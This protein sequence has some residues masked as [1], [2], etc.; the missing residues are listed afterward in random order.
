[1]PDPTSSL[2]AIALRPA[3]SAAIRHASRLFEERS[4]ADA[5]HNA[6]LLNHTISDTFNRI[7][8]GNVTDS[9]WRTLLATIDHKYIAPDFLKAPA[10]QDWLRQDVVEAHF[11]DLATD[12]IMGTSIDRTAEREHLAQAYSTFTGEHPRLANAPIDVV[13]GI[14]VAG[15]LASIP[16]SQRPLA[17]M[18]QQIHGSF[19]ER[20]D[21]L[22]ERHIASMTDLITERFPIV[23]QLLTP[24]AESVLS[25]ILSIR[26]LDP[27]GTRQRIRQLFKRAN[28]GD[29]S[30]IDEKVKH[31]IF[32]WA[33]RLCA[34]EKESLPL[35]KEIRALLV[36]SAPKWN[37]SIID[38]LICEAD[39][40]MDGALRR[41]RDAEGRD[42]RSVWFGLLIRAKGEEKALEWFDGENVLP[43]EGFFSGPGWVSWA[44]TSA[45]RGRWKE[46]AEVLKG[47][48]PMW[49]ETPA[50]AIVEGCVNAAFLLPEDFRSRVLDGVPLYHG[51]TPISRLDAIDHHSK[52]LECFG[53]ADRTLLG[54]VGKEWSML[55]A[56][57]SLWLQ[58]MDPDV[59]KR[60]AARERVSVEMGNGE[61]ALMLVPFCRSFEITYD[62]KPL[63]DYLRKRREL[64]GLDDRARVA[65][66]I[67]NAQ[68][69]NPQEFREYFDKNSDELTRVVPAEFFASRHVE[70][71]LEDESASTDARSAIERHRASLDEDHAKRLE[72][73]IDAHEGLDVRKKLEDLYQTTDNVIDLRNLIELL[74]QR[75]DREALRPLC[76]ELFRRLPTESG[77]IDVVIALSGPP[78]F[79]HEQI[80][81]FLKDNEH[82]VADSQR[83]LDLKS[84]ALIHAGLYVEAG[85][86]NRQSR[87]WRVTPENVRIGVN[88]AIA[89]GNWEA[90][91]GMV[92]EAWDLREEYDARELVALAHLAGQ[93]SQTLEQ[94][95]QLLKLAAERA[96]DDAA[97]LAAVYW[98]HFQLGHEEEVEARWLSRAME[99]SSEAGGPV[100]GM[101]LPEIVQDWLPKQRS[102][103]MEVERK[104]VQGEIPISVVAHSFNVS[105]ARMLVHVP[106]RNAE[107]SDGRRRM[108]L[109][110]IAADR[111]EAE[112]DEDWTVGI[113]VTSVL[114]L[115]Y[116]GILD[117]A[118][119]AFGHSRFS[120]DI[121]E[122]LYRERTDARFHQPSRVTSAKRFLRLQG[123]NRIE[124]MDMSQTPPKF[125]IDEVGRETAD[126]LQWARNVDGIAVCVRPIYSVGSLRQR[127]ANLGDFEPITI[128]LTSFSKWLSETG[129]IGEDVYGR[130]STVLRNSG[131]TENSL[132]PE[133]LAE[134]SICLDG[135]ALSYLNEA[136]A[137]QAIVSALGKIRVHGN[138]FHQMRQLAEQEDSE[139][140]I[141]ANIDAIRQ[142]IRSRIQE[143]KASFF[144]RPTK[145]FPEETAKAFRLE[146][147]AS[148]LEGAVECQAVCIDDRFLN[149]HSTFVGPDEIARPILT[150]L[151]TI[152]YLAKQERM[153]Q[154]DYYRVRHRLR[155]GG[156]AFVPL[157]P[158]E[159]CHWLRATRIWHGR[160]VE[161][162]ELR[163]LRQ[164]AARGDSL[165]LT[166][167]HQAFALAAN[168][169]A[170][171]TSAISGLWG[172]ADL[173]PET[174]MAHAG[175]IWRN[176]MATAVPGHRV[177][178]VDDYRRIVSEVVSLRIGSL[179][180][181]LPSRPRARQGDYANW[182]ENTVL[183]HLRPANEARIRRALIN[184]REA[185]TS[186]EVSQDAYG[187]LFLE[188]LPEKARAIVIR[189]EPEFAEKCGYRAERVFSIG[190]DL[191]V[192]DRNLFNAAA[193][194]LRGEGE[195]ITTDLGE[196]EIEIEYD[197]GGP[198]Y[199][200]TLAGFRWG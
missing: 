54:R 136:K 71:I 46:T 33:A 171:C 74:K 135:L 119:D 49:D 36:E 1:M 129:Q 42:A 17:G 60:D 97:V 191:Q 72:M 82:L 138:I 165:A 51:M 199:S 90:V 18:L 53:Y 56:D 102:H 146:A 182:I 24:H 122:H 173:E 77:A 137:L 175:W 161:T 63:E 55:L 85:E 101:S 180:L 141:I 131:D 9:W 115:Q 88:I 61:K 133:G 149:D 44:I 57:W 197:G 192:L 37:L 181:P 95:L 93:Q 80:L 70:S 145:Q 179:L 160:T 25:D 41:L 11:R 164:A 78:S 5:A 163:V 27:I 76:L 174:V 29:L 170:A 43:Y 4:A 132:A 112:I 39:G 157:E 187:N 111:P 7:R 151:D 31:Q 79:D 69:L 40:D 26:S 22:E 189:D 99:L 110:T 59:G 124:I 168:S 125:L 73:M 195:S 152:R 200:I 123:E 128:S 106:S 108:V 65:E 167:W 107:E 147:T 139:E 86:T 2:L 185:I 34:T 14:L 28:D 81:S 190:Q 35:A 52:A 12:I 117:S 169:R 178:D 91:G 3:L 186:L 172:D 75:G 62:P 126:V 64:G 193:K 98:Q 23:R 121:F 94:G 188:Q 104:W 162:V 32:E 150:V 92:A 116:L 20:L 127:N 83:L 50:L 130:I 134:K 198:A 109:P 143:G 66:F 153:T 105:L 48:R 67:V 87:T 30:P 47:L 114:V 118:L 120:P 100:W 38:A 194:A 158:E 16:S 176:L 21:D 154:E 15:Y 45:K 177:L 183:Q 155:V 196:K 58:L 113:D 89:S 166:N 140:E 148:L 159:I 156:F 19:N 103:L 142:T 184:S 6:D 96:P 84:M 68:F 13:T 8:G 10:V 144:S